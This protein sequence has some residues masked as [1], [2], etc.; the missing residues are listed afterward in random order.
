MFVGRLRKE[1]PASIKALTD[2]LKQKSVTYLDMS[3]NAFGPDGIK[4]WEEFA[5][6]CSSDLQVLKVNN[7]GISPLGGEMIALALRN[8]DNLKLKHFEAGRDRLENDGVT[9][10][11]AFF[12][13]AK[14]MEVISL[15]QNGI[16]VE[17]M[18][19]LMN[20]LVSNPQMR[21][22]RVNDNWLKD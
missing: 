21:E 22:L 20:S 16:K 13:R 14:T 18:T 7:C 8:N 1:I 19:A 4:G 15:P 5:K 3:D 17:G 6:E 9:A 11:A 2:G 10:L 12:K